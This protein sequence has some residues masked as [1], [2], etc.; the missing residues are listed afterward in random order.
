MTQKTAVEK[1]NLTQILLIVDLQSGLANLAR[2]FDASLFRSN[3]I[4]H[5]A[6]GKVF[7][8]PVIMTTSAENGLSSDI[9]RS[10]PRP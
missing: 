9:L 8:L 1:A 3:M 10:G 4:A 2:D 5:A 7:G 6:I